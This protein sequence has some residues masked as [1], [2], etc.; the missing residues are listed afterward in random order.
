MLTL[1]M[2]LV[3]SIIPLKKQLLVIYQKVNILNKV[4]PNCFDY[5]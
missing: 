5:F 3:N 4:K 1:F 2:N